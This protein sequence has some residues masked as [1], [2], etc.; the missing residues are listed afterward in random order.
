MSRAVLISDFV[1]GGEVGRP[2]L[3]FGEPDFFLQDTDKI[4]YQLF[5]KFLAQGLVIRAIDELFH[6][7]SVKFCRP[8]IQFFLVGRHQFVVFLAAC[9][10]LLTLLFGDASQSRLQLPPAVWNF[11]HGGLPLLG[12][13]HIIAQV[14]L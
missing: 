4:L 7:D 2:S 5:R 3:D 12:S 6:G 10:H 13:A 11:Q 9:C 14:L 1:S 8:H